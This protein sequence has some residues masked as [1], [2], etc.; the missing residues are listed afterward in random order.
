MNNALI[1]GLAVFVVIVSALLYFFWPCSKGF[2]NVNG[3]CYQV[4]VQK[5]PTSSVAVTDLK[6]LID[7]DETTSAGMTTE[8]VEL[9]LAAKEG[10]MKVVK[11]IRVVAMVK[12]PSTP[13]DQKA[14]LVL[15]GG[16]KS[17]EVLLPQTGKVVNTGALFPA[18]LKDVESLTLTVP[19]NVTLYE[20]QVV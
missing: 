12:A 19:A 18:D 17:L 4:L 3:K 10:K 16:D 14:K 1:I 20:V 5:E 6:K 15:K 11:G 7:N 13:T 8:P 2:T 9:T